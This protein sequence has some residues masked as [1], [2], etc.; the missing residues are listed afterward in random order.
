MQGPEG[1]AGSAARGPSVR[2]PEERQEE[3]GGL[4]T[5]C[6]KNCGAAHRLGPWFLTALGMKSPSGDIVD[7][8]VRTGTVRLLG[9][10][11]RTS[12]LPWFRQRFPGIMNH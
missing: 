3:K 12:V 9:E 10:S 4:P 8:S 7:P 6:W 11:H 1:T 5:Q 2:A